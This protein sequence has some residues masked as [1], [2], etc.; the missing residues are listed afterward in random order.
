M[1]VTGSK[2]NADLV[3]SAGIWFCFPVHNKIKARFLEVGKVFVWPG[4]SLKTM[5][6]GPFTIF[7]I[8]SVKPVVDQK[9]KK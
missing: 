5:G 6:A 7:L 3:W 8:K 9:C 1:R 2:A 4:S